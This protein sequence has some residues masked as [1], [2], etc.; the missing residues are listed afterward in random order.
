[1]GT[2]PCIPV[3]DP[4]A[5]LFRSAQ[6]Q[7]VLSPPGSP[8]PCPSVTGRCPQACGQGLGQ[9]LPGVS[10]P[11]AG[12]PCR[13]QD[14]P[15]VGDAGGWGSPS[16]HRLGVSRPHPHPH[17]VWGPAPGRPPCPPLA[18]PSGRGA[19]HAGSPTSVTPARGPAHR[20]REM[21][22]VQVQG[23]LLRM[24]KPFRG[25]AGCACGLAQAQPGR[26]H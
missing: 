19:R 23:W 26:L 16:L 5:S 22:V 10:G 7:A 14:A 4:P 2:Q 1:M 18:A 9:P 12:A 15:V 6:V 24:R 3:P 25:V 8:S 17:P 13:K 20:P 11:D 21:A